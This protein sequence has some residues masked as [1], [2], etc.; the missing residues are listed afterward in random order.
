[1][2]QIPDFACWAGAAAEELR[3]VAD[4]ISTAPNPAQLGEARLRF[5]TLVDSADD[6][7]NMLA[8]DPRI[9]RDRCL[10]M[11]SLDEEADPKAL[12]MAFSAAKGRS[13]LKLPQNNFGISNTLYVGSSCATG[14]RKGTLRK[15]LRQHLVCAPRGT[16]ALSLSEWTSHLQGG[17]IVRAWQY[18]SMGDG[19]EGDAAA[20]RVIL[21]V[22]DWLAGTM[23]PM[24]GRRGTRH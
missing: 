2:T 4:C 12:K 17:L 8:S 18:P 23:R 22:E 9:D 15:R 1:M 19:A 21:A 13:N 10:Y 16:Y 3:K 20:R 6:A 11:I 5:A 7:I 14:N 24:L